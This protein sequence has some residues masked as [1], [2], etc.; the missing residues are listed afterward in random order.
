MIKITVE[1]QEELNFVSDLFNR[2]LIARKKT[3]KEAKK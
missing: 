2:N 3:R 1:T